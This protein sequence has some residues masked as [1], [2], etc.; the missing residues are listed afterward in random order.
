MKLTEQWDRLGP[1]QIEGIPHDIWILDMR[2]DPRSRGALI[3]VKVAAKSPSGRHYI[4]RFH[5]EAERLNDEGVARAI[6]TIE[7][8]VRGGLPPTAREN[9]F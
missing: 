1:V 3:E 7:M 6:E 9:P 4:G 8:V 2:I 5:V